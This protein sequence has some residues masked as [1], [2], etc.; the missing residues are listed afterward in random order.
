M[1]GEWIVRQSTKVEFV[2]V[3]TAV[4]AD[5]YIPLAY[6]VIRAVYVDDLEFYLL[7]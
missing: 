3:V 6:N 7:W 5:Y 2:G 4:G 1:L